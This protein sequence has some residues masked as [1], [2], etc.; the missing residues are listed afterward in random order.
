MSCH[1]TSKAKGELIMETRELLLKGGKN[2][3]LWDT[4]A[5]DLGLMMQRIH[6]PVDDED[7]MPPKGKPQLTEEEA[8]ILHL[9]IKDGASFTKKVIELPGN[10]SLRVLAATFFK[11]PDVEVYDFA[12]VDEGTIT[13]LN[14]EYRV[15][16]PLAT[17][18]P[19]LSV[20]FY[21]VAQFKSEQLKDLD[22]IKDNIVSLHLA[23]MPVKDEDLKAIGNFTNL[24]DLNLAFTAIKGDGLKYLTSLKH[25]KQLSLS[26]TSVSANQLKPLMQ[27]KTLKSVK[28][29]NTAISNKDVASL[30][31]NFPNTNFGLG[32]NGD[33]VIAKLPTPFI[34]ADKDKNIFNKT[35]VITIKS[36]IGGAS[37][38]YTLDGSV[39]D[40]ISSPV[41]KKPF[42]INKSTIVNAKV[43]LKGWISS[44]NA[45]SGFYKS[46]LKPDSIHL[47][48]DPNP[49]YIVK[50]KKGKAF[51]DET[52]GSTNFNTAEWVGYKDNNLEA[53]LLFKQP[54]NISSVN[55][56]MLV[57]AGSYIMP[58]AEIQVWGGENTESLQ[59]LSKTTPLQ[60]TSN[61][62]SH[63]ENFTAT[64]PISRLKVIKLIVKQV[65]SLPNWHP[66]KGEK[67]WIFFD[68]IFLN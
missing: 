24:R 19:A 22:Q 44:D 54:V 4:T 2:G 68:E 11:S 6:L 52:L 66:G 35:S 29:W 34:K 65:K 27:V 28:V 51:F 59:L 49:R 56:N 31:A 17:A 32:Y 3:K 55:F 37:T 12:S 18:S 53:Y 26:G 57:D 48:T 30:K 36:P 62:S 14:T 40:S 58:P 33:T 38:R 5:V 20:N 47:L 45:S 9:W 23:K 39:P 10:D 25:L 42:S 43:F 7:H 61:S 63:L 64:F 8:R 15:I 67:A 21:G 60:P 41:Y 1:N 16:T 50:A 46:G 13:Q